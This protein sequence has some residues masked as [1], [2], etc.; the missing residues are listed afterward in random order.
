[1]RSEPILTETTRALARRAAY[2]RRLWNHERG[3]SSRVRVEARTTLRQVATAL[4]LPGPVDLLDL[5]KLREL[6]LQLRAANARLSADLR[7]CR[8]ALAEALGEHGDRHV[9]NT[10]WLTDP[11]YADL[12][13]ADVS[14]LVEL[15]RELQERLAV[16]RELNQGWARYGERVKARRD[17]GCPRCGRGMSDE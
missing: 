10:S 5:S 16:T 2:W 12:E 4:G 7:T 15:A 14:Y 17:E 9:L 11:S 1:M 3:Y 13:A 8:D 6:A